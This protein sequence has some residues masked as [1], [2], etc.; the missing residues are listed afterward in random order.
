MVFAPW[1]VRPGELP[2]IESVEQALAHPKL[3]MLTA[4]ARLGARD[5][6]PRVHWQSASMVAGASRHSRNDSIASQA[7]PR[8][9]PLALP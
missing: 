5:V 1:V 9:V 4:L 7:A 8:A 3:S 2:E 6:A